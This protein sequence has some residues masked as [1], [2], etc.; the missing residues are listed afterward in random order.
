MGLRLLRKAKDFKE[1]LLKTDRR[2][3]L[4]KQMPKNSICAEVG[5]YKGKLSERIL[6]LTNPKKLVLIDAWSVDVM[7]D[8]SDVQNSFTQNDFDLLY[9]DV[10]DKFLNKNNCEIIRKSSK[11]AL[12]LRKN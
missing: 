1:Y 5:V 7:C 8:N 4:L 2:D 10:C 3:F 11:E 12:D 6:K 9:S